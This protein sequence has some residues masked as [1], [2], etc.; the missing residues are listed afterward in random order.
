MSP[1]TYSRALGNI[2]IASESRRSQVV[3]NGVFGMLLFVASEAMLFAGLISGF[4]IIKSSAAIWPPPDQPRLPIEQ[5]AFNTLMLLASGVL[6]YYA[7]RLAKKDREKA[8]KPMMASLGLGAFFVIFQGYEWIGLIREGLTITSSSLGS[9]F[10]LIVGLH[11]L[12]AV[13]GLGVL[14]NA[15][16][17]I[18][19]GWIAHHTLAA[20]QVFW[21]FVVGLWPI[22]YVVVYL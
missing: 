2:S 17:K 4:M 14:F 10:Y 22:L 16:L 21:T 8:R 3:P 5:T 19:R 18:E 15:W 9:F 13:I 1:K 20:A 7:A 11:A 12:H 6:L